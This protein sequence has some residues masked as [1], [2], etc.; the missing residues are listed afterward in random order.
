MPWLTGR[1]QK[2]QPEVRKESGKGYKLEEFNILQ[3][4]KQ[5]NMATEN[6]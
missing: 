5:G 4:N 3:C 1:R 2:G 6:Q